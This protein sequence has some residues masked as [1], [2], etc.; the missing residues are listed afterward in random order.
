MSED[1]KFRKLGFW[2]SIFHEHDWTFV[3]GNISSKYVGF[4][5]T[6][7]L[8]CSDC[9]K[10][11]CH[12]KGHSLREEQFPSKGAA[13]VWIESLLPA[14]HRNLTISNTKRVSEE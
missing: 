4:A 14:G 7:T 8:E 11:V 9:G 5:A 3:D 10:R 12:M 2:E 1:R 13:K 6:V